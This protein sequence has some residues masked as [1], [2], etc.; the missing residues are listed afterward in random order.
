MTLVKFCHPG[1]LLA[2]DAIRKNSFPELFEDI[3]RN[4]RFFE[5][6]E[7]IPPANIHESSAGWRIEISAPGHEKNDFKVNLEKNLLMISMEK[8]KKQEPESDKG[9]SRKEFD[10]TSW[11]RRFILPEGTDMEKIT[12]EYQQ[13]I[14]TLVIP[15]KEEA[16]EKS[17]RQIDIL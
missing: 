17:V 7:T 10:Y 5:Q 4:N 1:N 16:K 6:I 2:N 13:G 15:K 9:F 3:F 11:N 12:A 14:L 8:E